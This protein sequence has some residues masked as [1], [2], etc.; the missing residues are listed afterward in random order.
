MILR[1]LISIVSIFFIHTVY[2]GSSTVVV[3]QGDNYIKVFASEN[4]NYIICEDI[5]LGNQ[6]VK[7]G[8]GCVLVFE[9]GSLANG[10]VIG[11]K[12]CVRAHDYEIFKRGYVRYRTYLEKGTPRNTPPSVKKEYHNCLIIEGTWNNKKCKD[13]WTGLLNHND[14]DVMLALKNFITLHKSGVKIKLPTIT[15]L[16]YERAVIPGN[17]IIDFNNSKISYPDDLSAWED[18]S[19]EIPEG[20]KP[21]K[22]ETGY[23]L[24]TLRSNTTIENLT[25]DGKSLFRQDEPVRLGVSC[26]L[27]VGN[28]Q[29]VTIK[30]VSVINIL[31]PAV[32]VQSEAKD[33]LFKICKFYNIGEHV[34]YSHQYKGYCHFEECVFDTWDSDRVSEYRNGIDYL[35]KHKPIREKGNISFDELYK[36]DLTF[37]G[38]IFNNP[39]RI[40]SQRR[41]LGGFFTGTFPVVVNIK[42]C[43]FQ[44]TLPIVNPGIGSAITEEVEKPYRMIYH[45][46]DGAPYV[47]SAKSNCN[48]I[49]EFFDCINIPFR[50]VYAKCYYNCK[51]YLD[52]FENNVEN[53]T[54]AFKAEF[55][56]PMVIKN[57]EFTDRGLT[58]KIKHPVYHR[59][60]VFENCNFF[61]ASNRESIVDVLTYKESAE[62][63]AT[64]KNCTI[65]IPGYRLVGGLEKEKVNIINCKISL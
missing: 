15:A 51:L 43:S 58:G 5:D 53:V 31:G 19:I 44:G 23:G 33:L 42:K 41:T 64:F 35:Y 10:T 49:M 56:E 24:I 25:L 50:T 26:I 9:G 16:G 59:P 22:L 12:T 52:V 30:N 55:S 37:N 38:C 47:Y 39:H 62:A 48:I 36:F 54:S 29:N 13:N 7:I 40:N 6:K 60:V 4:T 28:S 27:A 17:H 20:T 57:C 18:G 11:N 32:T 2:A 1:I 21:C 3:K 34:V 8:K 45:S 61:C 46:C 65:D 63:I 14:E